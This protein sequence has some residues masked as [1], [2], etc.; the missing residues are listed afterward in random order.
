MNHSTLNEPDS[1]MLEEYD[2]S[3]GIRGKYAEKYY[4]DR[5]MVQLDE[6][7]AQTFPDAKSVNDALRAL[8]KIISEN[9]KKVP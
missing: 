4:A 8:A 1:D 2:F 9:Q 5:N 3:T 7:V 6:D